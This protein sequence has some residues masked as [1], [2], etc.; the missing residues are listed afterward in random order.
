[1]GTPVIR[2]ENKHYEK[3]GDI[4]RLLAYIAG[5]GGN[6][7]KEKA[8]SVHGRGISDDYKKAPK[9]MIN[10]QKLY[11]KN[12]ERRCYHMVISFSE[13]MNDRN[14]AILAADAVA[15]IIFEE[16]HY[17]VFYGVHTSTNHLHI[18]FAINA[19]NFRSGKK[20]HQNKCEI[21]TFSEQIRIR[22]KDIGLESLNN[23][24]V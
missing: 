20:W 5:K 14:I 24:C 6:K 4:H 18:H 15:T 23:G 7:D 10:I 12:Q 13:E 19:V 3:D 11:G 8:V 1:M 17:Q 21:K 22:I 16:M 9:Q 2:I